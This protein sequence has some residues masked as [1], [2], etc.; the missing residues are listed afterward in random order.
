MNPD[1]PELPDGAVPLVGAGA[2]PLIVDVPK[3]KLDSTV[4]ALVLAGDL[5]EV[6]RL[7]VG[8]LKENAL[9]VESF[10]DLAV[11]ERGMVE[12]ERVLAQA[13]VAVDIGTA[14]SRV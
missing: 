4:E 6:A 5:C 3:A 12:V 11:L 14:C 13:K 1:T 8:R 10:E 9:R 7:L 2:G